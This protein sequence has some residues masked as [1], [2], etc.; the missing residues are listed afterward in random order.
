MWER[1]KA[2]VGSVAQAERGADPKLSAVW[3]ACEYSN[4][5]VT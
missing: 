4:I 1:L 3:P 5:Q 2:T